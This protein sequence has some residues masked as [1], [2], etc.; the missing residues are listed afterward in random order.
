MKHM[1]TV[2]TKDKFVLATWKKD[3]VIRVVKDSDVSISCAL[4]VADG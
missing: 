4:Y 3:A 1:C 2:L